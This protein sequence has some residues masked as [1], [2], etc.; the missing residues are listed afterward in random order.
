MKAPSILLSLAPL[1]LSAGAAGQISAGQAAPPLRLTQLLQASPGAKVDWPSLHGKVVVLEFWATWCPSCIEEIPHLNSVVRSTGSSQVQFIAV[2]DEPPE[3][4]EKFV[5]GLPIGGWLG[6]DTTGQTIRAYGAETRPRTVVVDPQGRIA[7]ILNPAQ[8]TGAALLN[9]AAGNKVRFPPDLTAQLNTQASHD[10]AKLDA[11]AAA[12]GNPLFDVSVRP[13]DSGGQGSIV[14][15]SV[16][17]NGPVK[18]DVINVPLLMLTSFMGLPLDRI[19]MNDYSSARYSLHVAAPTGTL[20]Q[21]GPAIQLAVASAAKL[22]LVRTDNEQD[23]L[24]LEKTPQAATLLQ[25]SATGKGHVCFFD[26]GTQKL[27]LQRCSLDKIAEAVENYV[28]EPVLN[29][30]GIGGEFSAIVDM[31][32]TSPEALNAALHQNLG[33]TLVRARRKV[34]RIAFEP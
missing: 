34:E 23:A 14:D 24:V 4:V 9:L 5:A 27:I 10:A 25:A 13:G 33:L 8:L 26:R 20:Q 12:G 18:L 16:E 1:M 3:T 17:P 15:N 7:A 2:D 21:L 6:I 29:E 11:L 22:H 28:G 19:R 31:S 32:Q 30:T